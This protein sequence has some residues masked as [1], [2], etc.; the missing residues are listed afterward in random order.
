[1]ARLKA[2]T[3]K[4]LK[5][6]GFVL[7]TVITLG[8]MTTLASRCDAEDTRELSVLDYEVGTLSDTDGKKVKNDKSGLVTKDMYNLDGFTVEL[9][10]DPD[11]M[12]Q[13]NFYDE[14]KAWVSV[15]TYK[16]DF[17][18]EEVETLKA[19]GIKY[20]KLEIIPLEDED[21]EV[22]IF[23]KRGYVKQLTVTVST[24]DAETSSE[25]KVESAE[26]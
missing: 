24:E 7:V 17:D 6:V 3:K 25:E 10:K 13:L 1:M 8:F 14:E 4:L 11:V 22:G 16:K 5:A 12:Y 20:V 23:E 2:K 15:T 21:E 19:E 26:E 18:G 9:D